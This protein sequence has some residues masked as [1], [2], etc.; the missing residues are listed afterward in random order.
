MSEWKFDKL[1]YLSHLLSA[2]T[3]VIVSNFIQ[4][5]LLIFTL[6]GLSFTVNDCI[7]CDNTILW[8]IHFNNLE[9]DLS[10]TTTNCEE[11]AL[12]Y[13]T[14]CLSEVWRKED[15]EERAGDALDSVGNRENSNTLGL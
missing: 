15:I 5:A 9:L 13:R 3:N 10:H 4:V 1:S 2:S 8:R 14:V 11:I 12:S 6:N 7:L